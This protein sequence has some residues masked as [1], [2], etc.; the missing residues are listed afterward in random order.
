MTRE[1]VLKLPVLEIL[2]QPFQVK[3][4]LS[5]RKPCLAALLVAT[6]IATG[7]TL[8]L[9]GMVLKNLLYLTADEVICCLG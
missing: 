3:V 7:A 8:P 6:T 5:G 1:R 9:L 2:G 4:V